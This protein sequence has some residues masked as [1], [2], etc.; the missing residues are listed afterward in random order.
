LSDT[1]IAHYYLT[2]GTTIKIFGASSTFLGATIG[3]DESFATFSFK[4]TKFFSG[5]NDDNTISNFN[6]NSN[7]NRSGQKNY[8]NM[9]VT[10]GSRMFYGSTIYAQDL[11]FD[12]VKF[13]P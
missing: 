7:Y 2:S 9:E 11:T 8:L 13:Y 5:Y 1:N 12:D 10:S 3:S 6:V 4:E